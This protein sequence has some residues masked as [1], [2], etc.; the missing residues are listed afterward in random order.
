MAGWG[1]RDSTIV[2]ALFYIDRIT[3]V[4]N[5][6]LRKNFGNNLQ[7]LHFNTVDADELVDLYHKYRPRVILV[8]KGNKIIFPDG[9]INAQI[10][11]VTDGELQMVTVQ[12]E[13]YSP[14]KSSLP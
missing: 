7:M 4:E 9:K 11:C 10:I 14:I 2:I 13:P 12:Y 6:V 3:P 5:E 8:R 1:V